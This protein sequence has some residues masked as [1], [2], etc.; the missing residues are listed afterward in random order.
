LEATA[1]ALGSDRWQRRVAALKAIQARRLD[2][3]ASSGYAAMLGSPYP[4]ER[5]WLARTLAASPNPQASEDLIRMVDDPQVNVR[6]MAVQALAQRRDPRAV[7]PILNLLKTSDEWYDQLY[8]YQ[9]LRAL[10]WDQTR[11]H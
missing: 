9:A 10:R 5:Y 2:I 4:Q 3:S 11:L 6:T 8:A 7:Q 1:A